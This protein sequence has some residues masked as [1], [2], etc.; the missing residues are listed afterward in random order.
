MIALA[1]SMPS[2]MQSKFHECLDKDTALKLAASWTSQMKSWVNFQADLLLFEDG[3][4]IS[5]EHVRT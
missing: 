4:E 2:G 5:R 3:K 1:I